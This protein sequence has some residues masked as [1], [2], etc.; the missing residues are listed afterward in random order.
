MVLGCRDKFQLSDRAQSSS[1]EE[2]LALF[3]SFKTCMQWSPEAED[4]AHFNLKTN[5]VGMLFLRILEVQLKAYRIIAQY[6]LAQFL[7]P[8]WPSRSS[9]VVQMAVMSLT[10]S[11]EPPS[12]RA[13]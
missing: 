8:L 9:G 2:A 12:R 11:G 5:T 3:V 6:Q 4:R 13:G 10:S 1:V 7:V